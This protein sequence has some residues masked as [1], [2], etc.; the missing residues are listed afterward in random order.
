MQ[1]AYYFIV[2]KLFLHLKIKLH[3]LNK[4]IC[5]ISYDGAVDIYM[6]DEA[7]QRRADNDSQDRRQ[8]DKLTIAQGRAV[9]ERTRAGLA[10]AEIGERKRIRAS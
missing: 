9:V 1:L 7:G 2:G 10:T 3:T 4:F 5:K 8:K 6:R